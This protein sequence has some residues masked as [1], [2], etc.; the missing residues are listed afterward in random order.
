MAA[1]LGVLGS[2]S[3][4]TS[5]LTGYEVAAAP[6][7]FCIDTC[8]LEIAVGTVAGFRYEITSFLDGEPWATIEVEHA[9]RLGL[10]PRW[11]QTVDEPEFAIRLTGR[12]TMHMTFGTV[13]EDR[14]PTATMGLVELNAARMV[15]LIPAVVAA[16]PGAKSFA[17]LPIVT[18]LTRTRT[19]GVQAG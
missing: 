1:A 8:G 3:T 2:S 9:A 19:G 12:P 4:W 15:N 10:G 11:R 14:S 7:T 16:G 13:S 17:E 6:D 18:S 5:R